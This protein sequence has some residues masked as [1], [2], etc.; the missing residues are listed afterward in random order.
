MAG[1]GGSGAFSITPRRC[2][3]QASQSRGQV[4]V[5][6]V[7]PGYERLATRFVQRSAKLGAKRLVG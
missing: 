7:R 6:G 4:P 5:A 3:R 2:G 1:A